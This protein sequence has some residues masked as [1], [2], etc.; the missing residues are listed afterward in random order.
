MY[1]QTIIVGNLGRDPEMRYTP[2]GKAVT[3][4]SVAVNRRYQTA[5]GQWEDKTTWFKV[6][7]WGKLAESTNQYLKKGSRVLVIGR[8]DASAWI[9]QDGQPRASLELTAFDV[10]FL[11]GREGSEASSGMDSGPAQQEEDIPF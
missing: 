10:R 9:G 5:E 2:G 11:S 7:C 6:A 1:Q 4:F 3:D 8:V